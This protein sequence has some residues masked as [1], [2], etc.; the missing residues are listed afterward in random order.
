MAE[1]EELGDVGDVAGDGEVEEI[2]AV[3][4][5]VLAGADG[6][7][8]G[9]SGGEFGGG[10]GAGAGDAAGGGVVDL[11]PFVGV[12]E[13]HGVGVDDFDGG[14]G[15]A[16]EGEFDIEGEFLLNPEGAAVID[17]AVDGVDDE[18]AGGVFDGDDAFGVGVGGEEVED[19]ANGDEGFDGGAGEAFFGEEV[20]E[21]TDRAEAGDDGRFSGVCGERHE[22]TCGVRRSGTQA[23][24][25]GRAISGSRRRE[26]RR[27]R[28]RSWRSGRR[29]GCRC[30]SWAG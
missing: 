6:G 2:E 30:R 19:I 7:G 25:V 4:E 20:G 9:F 28:L 27:G 13:G 11:Q 15:V 22:K 14:A 21:A 29:R 16:Q 8:V 3:T 24:H 17:E 5:G 12:E 23:G 26:P 10:G 18:A 1:A